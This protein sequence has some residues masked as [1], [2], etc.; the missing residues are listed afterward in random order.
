MWVDTST[1]L[2]HLISL[3][4]TYFIIFA[5]IYSTLPYPTI[6]LATFDEEDNGDEE[7]E[8][9]EEEEDMESAIDLSH[10]SDEYSK[11]VPLVAMCL[12]G[13]PKDTVLVTTQS[14]SSKKNKKPDP[15]GMGKVG[16]GNS[17]PSRAA[18]TPQSSAQ[19]LWSSMC[20]HLILQLRLVT[21][22]PAVGYLIAACEFLLSLLER[23]HG[24]NHAGVGSARN[25]VATTRGSGVGNGKTTSVSAAG[26][27]GSKPPSSAESRGGLL[28]TSPCVNQ[29]ASV[30]YS[31]LLAIEDR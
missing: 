15:I 9:E 4:T 31:D 27:T 12:A 19:S 7:E 1:F 14:G 16:S 2:Y 28:A 30:L 13:F 24:V 26:E 3:C 18:T 25:K 21:E 23:D 6:L 29:F 5:D 11:L 22:R 20:R 8:E 17:S 10:V